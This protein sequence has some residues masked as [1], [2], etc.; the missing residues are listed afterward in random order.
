VKYKET[1]LKAS[2]YQ[3]SEQHESCHQHMHAQCSRCGK[4][5]HLENKIFRSAEKKLKADY[6]I[7]I[8]YGKTV[9]MGTCK[10]CQE[11]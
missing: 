2:C 3:Y 9:I 4:I 7:Q 10:D 1:D 5:F 6:G 11:L 8:D